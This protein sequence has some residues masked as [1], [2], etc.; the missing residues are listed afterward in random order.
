MSWESSAASRAHT[1]SPRAAARTKR[2]AVRVAALTTLEIE[3]YKG[4]VFLTGAGVS[5]ASGLPTYRGI[6]GLWA[7]PETAKLND[8]GVFQE[9]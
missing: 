9:R 7:D 5:A 2:Y 3:K 4:I 8:A 6:G 1:R